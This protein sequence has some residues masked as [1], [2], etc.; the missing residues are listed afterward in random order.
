LSVSPE[1]L[2]ALAAM[3][4]VSFF[5]RAG[6]FFLMRF[7]TVTPRLEAAISAIPLAVMIG[8]IAPAVA[9]GQPA[10]LLGVGSVIVVTKTAGNDL[11]AALAGVA[12]VAIARAAGF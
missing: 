5:C 6:G 8:I 4:A 10:E 7:V 3:A 1:F 11:L 9:K 12:A 2:M